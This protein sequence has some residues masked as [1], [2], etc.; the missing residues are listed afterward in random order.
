MEAVDK[1]YTPE[2][3]DK[4]TCL[5]VQTIGSVKSGRKGKNSASQEEDDCSNCCCPVQVRRNEHVYVL[6][7]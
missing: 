1:V 2:C 3:N 5:G 6:I 7:L 4:C